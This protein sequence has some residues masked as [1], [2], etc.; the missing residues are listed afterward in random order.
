[1]SSGRIGLFCILL[2]APALAHANSMEEAKTHFLLG[3]EQFKQHRYPTALAEFEGSY[4]LNAVPGVLFNIALTQRELGRNR[5]SYVTFER[6]VAAVSANISPAQKAETDRQ[7]ATVRGRLFFLSLDIPAD[8]QVQVDGQTAMPPYTRIIL[9]P[10]NHKIDVSAEGR[11]PATRLVVAREG[12]QQTLAIPLTPKVVAAA[13]PPAVLTTSPETVTSTEPVNQPSFLR[14]PRGIAALS[15]G[16]FSA[17][18]FVI[19]AATGGA[20]LSTKHT[21]DRGCTAGACDKSTYDSGHRLAVASD[22]F[23]G[24]GLASAVVTTVVVLTRPRSTTHAARTLDHFVA[25]AGGIGG[26]F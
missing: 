26:V 16:I 18:S 20:A 24:I 13:P 5:E 21:Y 15:L 12:G 17:T 4:R 7:M 3:V 8:A 22:V 11:E 2:C 23:L 10:G 25:N 6:Y 9:D 14:T 19:E 1:M